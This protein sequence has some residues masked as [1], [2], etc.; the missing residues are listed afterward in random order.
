VISVGGFS[1]NQH[2]KKS[3]KIS[4]SIKSIRVLSPLVATK[5]SFAQNLLGLP[6]QTFLT[7]QTVKSIRNHAETI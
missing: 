7:C 3:P 2:L 5:I 6:I 4:E 1:E